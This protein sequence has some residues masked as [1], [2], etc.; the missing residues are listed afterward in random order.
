MN[1]LAFFGAVCVTGISFASITY[2]VLFVDVINDVNDIS[3]DIGGLDDNSN[4]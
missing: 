1:I 3:F 2:S 4:R